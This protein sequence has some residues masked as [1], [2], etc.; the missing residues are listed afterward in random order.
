MCIRDSDDIGDPVGHVV[1]DLGEVRPVLRDDVEVYDHALAVAGHPHALAQLV[2]RQQL[3]DAVTQ[4]RACHPY[5]PVA[6][7]GGVARDVREDVVAY[8]DL[9]GAGC[10]HAPTSSSSV[11]R[12]FRSAIRPSTGMSCIEATEERV[13]M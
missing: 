1:R 2:E 10:G 3:S 7:E 5:D 9:T 12:A 13:S 4:G 11:R 6:L 8:L